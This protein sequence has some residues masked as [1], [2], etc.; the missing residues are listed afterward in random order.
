MSCDGD[1]IHR[2]RPE[3]GGPGLDRAGT[4]H[5]R[6]QRSSSAR[7][8]QQPVA[9]FLLRRLAGLPDPAGLGPV[10]PSRGG[11]DRRR[12]H[13]HDRLLRHLPAHPVSLRVAA[14]AGPLRTRH[15]GRAGRGGLPGVRQELDA[16]VDLRIGRG[17][18]RAHVGLRQPPGL[19]RHLRHHRLLPA[20]LLDHPPRPG[21]HPGR[22]AACPAHRPGHDGVPDADRPD[23]RAGPGPRDGRQAGHER[24]KAPAGPGHAR[25]DR[26]VAVD[27]HAEVRAGRQAPGQ[28]AVLGRTR[29]GA[30]RAR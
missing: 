29:R 12:H 7:Y 30:H 4:A 3:R 15:P 1:K 17:R 8:R 22:P 24:R 11:V 2:R 18:L 27:D 10:P 5:Q 13:H 16:A 23:A 21:Y 20:V 25:P 19:L 9:L 14:A 28:A 26:P 6:A